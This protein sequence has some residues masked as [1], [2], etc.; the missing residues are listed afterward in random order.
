MNRVYRDWY[1]QI[2]LALAK[3]KGHKL[4][5]V[6]T[7]REVVSP[8][9]VL[10]HVEILLNLVASSEPELGVVIETIVSEQNQSSL[11]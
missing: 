7:F 2:R 4:H 10:P 6:Y 5:S 9:P 8:G 1:F 11:T 3:A